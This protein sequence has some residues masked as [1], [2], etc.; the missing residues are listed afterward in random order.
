MSALVGRNESMKWWPADRDLGLPRASR[1]DDGLRGCRLHHR[2]LLVHQVHRVDRRS[3]GDDC[4][5]L[6]A[7]GESKARLFKICGFALL[8]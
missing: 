8:A 7:G 1:T 6:T 3:P 2:R 5:S 4:A